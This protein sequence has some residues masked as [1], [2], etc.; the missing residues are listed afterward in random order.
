MSATTATRKQAG[1]ERVH[2]AVPAIAILG[3]TAGFLFA[4]LSGQFTVRQIR[5]VGQGLPVA[6]IDQSARVAGQNIFTV[7]SD[8]VIANLSNLQRVAVRRVDVSFPDRVTIYARMRRAMAAWR[9]SSGLYLL[10]PDGRIIRSVKATRLPI[11]TSTE[12]NSS[13]GPGV[14]EAVHEA[15]QLLPR[16]PNGAITAFQYGP[17]NGLSIVGRTGWQATVGMGTRR[18]MVDRIA[19]LA[20]VLRT[21]A[22]E[23]RTFKRIDL[24][25]G[26]PYGV[27]Q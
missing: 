9:T 17:R 20:E 16:A 11:I 12:Q 1:A 7:R 26:A 10:D 4:A 18:T 15:V 25:T 27:T 23:G 21:S 22:G 24:R 14:V 8:V 3:L 2:P 19:T 5:V 13:L 6:A